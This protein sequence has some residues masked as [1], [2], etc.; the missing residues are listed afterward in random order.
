MA[1]TGLTNAN[2]KHNK[3]NKDNKK[4]N[5]TYITNIRYPYETTWD[6][7]TTSDEFELANIHFSMAN[8]IRR[9]IISHI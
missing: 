4:N 6:K 8:A 2:T 7:T 5:H 1:G 9:L 3:D